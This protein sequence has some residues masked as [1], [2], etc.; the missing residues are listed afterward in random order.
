MISGKLT[1]VAQVSQMASSPLRTWSFLHPF[2]FSD[3][4][5]ELRTAALDSQIVD[6]IQPGLMHLRFRIETRQVT[7]H[8][9]AAR[10]G[11]EYTLINN[12]RINR[13][14][15]HLPDSVLTN[16]TER[17]RRSL[18]DVRDV[19]QREFK[20]NWELFICHDSSPH[21]AYVSI[22]EKQWPEIYEVS[23]SFLS[24]EKLGRVKE[25]DGEP[26]HDFLRGTFRLDAPG[27]D[28]AL[29]D[30]DSMTRSELDALWNLLARQDSWSSVRLR[31]V[32]LDN[33]GLREF[34][35]SLE[36]LDGTPINSA[37]AVVFSMRGP[38][39]RLL[40][41]ALKGLG[42]LNPEEETLVDG[43]LATYRLE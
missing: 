10:R 29:Q 21:E 19:L 16:Y 8:D 32:L 34:R 40:L 26:L 36:G 39:L 38:D 27:A 28:G 35:I 24:L 23:S 7:E 15:L 30:F 4:A 33:A 17:F 18:R 43:I 11:A 41:Q 9:G 37:R 1:S 31:A 12:D 14:V 42:V 20:K 5:P 25:L 13:V 6:A 22:V 3:A 2:D